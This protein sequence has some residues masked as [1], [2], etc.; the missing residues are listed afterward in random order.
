MCG[1]PW[2]Y[3]EPLGWGQCQGARVGGGK[4]AS[5]DWEQGWHSLRK[6]SSW[7]ATVPSMTFGLMRRVQSPS[8][9][10]V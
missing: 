9:S 5:E 7:A 6:N 10:E 3:P 2:R 1:V 4:Q 8:A